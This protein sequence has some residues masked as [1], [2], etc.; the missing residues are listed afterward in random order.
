[1]QT[2]PNQRGKTLGSKRALGTLQKT[3]KE[4]RRLG[5]LCQLCGLEL[6]F[7]LGFLLALL[8]VEPFVQAHASF[9]GSLGFVGTLTLGQRLGSQTGCGSL[10]GRSFGDLSFGDRALVAGA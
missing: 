8:A 9:R 3:T 4:A 7:R 1:M 2:A 6:G 5:R 10:G